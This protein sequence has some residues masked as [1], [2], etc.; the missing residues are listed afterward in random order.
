LVVAR[1]NGVAYEIR[2]TRSSR[3]VADVR[4]GPRCVA[5]TRLG[6]AVNLYIILLVY[7]FSCLN[8]RTWKTGS[9]D[10]VVGADAGRTR[11]RRSRADCAARGAVDAI[12]VDGRHRVGARVDANGPVVESVP[13][14]ASGAVGGRGAGR[15]TLRTRGARQSGRVEVEA[16]RTRGRRGCRCCCAGG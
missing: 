3:A 8:K 1:A 7:L 5:G 6:V 16:D 4:G 11:R 10:V 13:G 9:L 12:A 14:R 2:Q 15:A